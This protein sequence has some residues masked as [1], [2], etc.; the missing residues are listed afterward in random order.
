MATSNRYDRSSSETV[1][2]TVEVGP[3]MVFVISDET[4]P[5]LD[6]LLRIW[7]KVIGW[8]VLVNYIGNF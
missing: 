2:V 6:W 3:G 8:L 4:L 5:M 7:P 1:A